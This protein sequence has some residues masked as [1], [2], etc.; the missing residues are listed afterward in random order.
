MIIIILDHSFLSY[1]ADNSKKN[2]L[3]DPVT[4]DVSTPKP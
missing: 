2:A 1:A 3:I 4:F